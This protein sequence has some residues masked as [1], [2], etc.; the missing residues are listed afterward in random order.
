MEF[1][2]LLNLRLEHLI[3]DLNKNRP[4]GFY[5]IIFDPVLTVHLFFQIS[6]IQ[7]PQAPE[8]LQESQTADSREERQTRGQGQKERAE[9]FLSSQESQKEVSPQ[10][11]RIQR[12]KTK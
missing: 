12:K 5:L 7:F 10:L 8:V 3:K 9:R 1:I 4:L 6:D 11:E 2:N